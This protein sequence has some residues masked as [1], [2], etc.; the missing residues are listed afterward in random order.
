MAII[1]AATDLTRPY[2]DNANNGK[3]VIQRCND[4]ANH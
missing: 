3:L 2:W 1:P 4:Y